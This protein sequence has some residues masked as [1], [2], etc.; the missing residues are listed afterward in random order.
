MIPNHNYPVYPPRSEEF[1]AFL[2]RV[3]SL[4]SGYQPPKRTGN[5]QV[6][7][8]SILPRKELLMLGYRWSRRPASLGLIAL[9]GGRSGDIIGV[10]E[11][12]LHSGTLPF[13]KS[14]GVLTYE[15]V[16]GGLYGYAMFNLD[17]N[18]PSE[19]YQV[20]H[21]KMSD[22]SVSPEKKPLTVEEFIIWI[23]KSRDQKPVEET[24]PTVNGKAHLRPKGK[25]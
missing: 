23:Y 5:K 6:P 21:R 22:V 2:D 4:M 12:R 1:G 13:T 15:G 25:T 20:F 7:Q 16:N 8:G 11:Q 24:R 14:I 18:G 3:T 19:H 9:D 10:L 17:E